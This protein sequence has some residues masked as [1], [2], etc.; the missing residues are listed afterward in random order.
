MRAPRPEESMKA[1][2]RRL[3]T[4]RLEPDETTSATNSRSL[5]A[6]TMF[7]RPAALISAYESLTS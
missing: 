3:T 6:E 5:G 1:V 7:S 2:S 4:I